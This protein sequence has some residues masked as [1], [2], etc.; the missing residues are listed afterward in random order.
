MLLQDIYAVPSVRPVEMITKSTPG[1]GRP[2][3]S[4][5]GAL[6][7]SSGIGEADLIYWGGGGGACVGSPGACPI[8]SMALFHVVIGNEMSWLLPS[9]P[10]CS[11]GI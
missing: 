11:L 10:L 6:E 1:A 3:A 5:E 7:I 4:W 9:F 2:W 8:Q